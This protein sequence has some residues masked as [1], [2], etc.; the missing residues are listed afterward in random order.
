MSLHKEISFEVEI[1]QR[2]CRN[3]WLYAEGD[4]A[5]YDR[6][7]PLFPP[8]VVAWVQATQPKAWETLFKNHGAQTGETLLARLRDQLDQRGTLDVLRH[9]IELLGLKQPLK[10]AEFKPALAINP[11]I[12]ERYAANRLG[13]VRQVRYSLHGENCIDLVLFLNCILV[14]AQIANRRSRRWSRRKVS[15]PAFGWF[16]QNQFYCVDGSFPRRVARCHQQQGLT[17]F[18]LRLYWDEFQNI[19]IALPPLEEKRA[20]YR[21]IAAR[22]QEFDTLAAKA[23]RAIGLLQE[24]R[25]ALICAAVT[26]Q[27]DVRTVRK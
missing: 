13:I 20:I 27:I 26:G 15:R 25:T 14:D 8:D 4:A 17:D 24:S 22:E 10:V 23:Q 2:L 18:R 7:K 11:D 19:W 1:C 21:K 16:R 3:G 12:L 9:G 6:A 5:Q